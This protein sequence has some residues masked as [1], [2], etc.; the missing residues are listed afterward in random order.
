VGLFRRREPLHER[1]ARE[2]GLGE[3]QPIDPRTP[4]QETGVHGLQRP[5]EW[6]A[7]VTADAPGVEGDA[8]RFVVLPDRTLLVEE[9]SDASLDPLA[10][11]VEQ[12]LDPPYRARAAR[13]SGTLWAVQAKRI[14]VVAI[15]NGPDGDAIELTRTEDGSTTLSVDDARVFG[16]IPALEARGQREGREYVVRAERLD[17]D[18]W[19]VHAA[20]L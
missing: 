20:A 19:D 14:E 17:G 8:V 1:L 18:L 9:G 6:D 2:G 15:P 7:T 13:Q 11:A 3:P 10:T 12:T 5:R 4:W 16:S